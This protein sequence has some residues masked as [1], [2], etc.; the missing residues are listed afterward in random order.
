MKPFDFEHLGSFVEVSP[1]G[2]TR[3][4]IGYQ[5]V[6]YP[7]TDLIV[8]TKK[9]GQAVYALEIPLEEWREIVEA[10]PREERKGQ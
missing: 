8:L 9:Q 10:M 5:Y 7:G 3:S 2:L 6:S 1:R 4:R